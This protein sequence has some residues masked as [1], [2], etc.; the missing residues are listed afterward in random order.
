MK[1]STFQPANLFSDPV[2]NHVQKLDLKSLQWYLVQNQ[3]FEEVE[4]ILAAFDTEDSA[5]H[6]KAQLN[7]IKWTKT[8]DDDRQHFSDGFQDLTMEKADNAEKEGQNIGGV[9]IG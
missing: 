6:L 9:R 5:L 3:R 2:Y 7:K 1:A 4:H 8:T